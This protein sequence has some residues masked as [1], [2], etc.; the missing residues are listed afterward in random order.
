MSQQ[1]DAQHVFQT[2]R[3]NHRDPRNLALHVVGFW[4]VFRSLKKLITGHLFAAATTLGAGL[5]LL[6][7]GHQLEGSDAF[8]MFRDLR[9][10]RSGNGRLAGATR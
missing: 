9:E 5:A 7:G 10:Q 2:F 8:A 1:I 3:A 6:I 4:L